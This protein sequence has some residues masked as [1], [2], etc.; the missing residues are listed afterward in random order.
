MFALNDSQKFYF[1]EKST[2]MRKGFDGLSGLVR[3]GMQR[4][5]ISGEIFIFVNKRRNMM[6]LLHWQA[7]GFVLY[8]KRLEEGTFKIP[9]NNQKSIL[10]SYTELSMIIAG[11]WTKI[12]STCDLVTICSIDDTA[13]IPEVSDILIDYYKSLEDKK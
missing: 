13:N 7:G 8:F 3:T 5:P 11:I 1:Y 6:K 9:K 2:D 12:D 4:N 10:I